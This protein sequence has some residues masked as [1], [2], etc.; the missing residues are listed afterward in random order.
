M[1]TNEATPNTPSNA[2]AQMMADWGIMNAVLGGTKTM[3][4]AGRNLLPQHQAEAQS[5]YNARLEKA[6][7]KN[8]TEETIGALSGKPFSEPIKLGDDIPADVEELLTNVDAE[9]NTLDSFAK[10]WF[11]EGIAKGFSHV[12]VEFPRL[13]PKQDGT[14]RTL[15][16]DRAE[17]V[18]PYLV[19][20]VPEN[21]I[22]ARTDI[23]GGDEV[24][25]HARIRRTVT[26]PYGEWGEQQIVE[27]MVLEPNSVRLYRQKDQTKDDSEWVKVDEWTTG[28]NFVPL[29]TFYT[30]KKDTLLSKP[31]L[32]D[33]AYVNVR[34]W[35]SA[36]DQD[37]S[38]SAA[39]FP[40]M[41]VSG[42]VE[43]DN[44]EIGP[45]KFLSTEN[46]QGKFYYVEHKGTAL[47]SGADDLQAMEDWMGSYGSE[48]LRKKSGNQTATARALDSAESTSKLQAWA[49]DFEDRLETV[50][51]F[52]KAWISNG[53]DFGGGTLSLVTDFAGSEIEAG[54]LEALS[55]SRDRKD[56]SRQAWIIE[57]KRRD[58]IAEDFDAEMDAELLKEEM[59][60]L[61]DL[62]GSI[63]DLDAGAN[64]EP[65][66]EAH[67]PTEKDAGTKDNTEQGG[68]E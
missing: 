44:F 49:L 9:G 21:L 41:A 29:V 55:K 19:H 27:I 46:T 50:L 48:F 39:R 34:H 20:V 26:I 16:D 1:A 42:A 18:R 17:G 11:E 67:K 60:A 14:A 22:F 64:P 28:I 13:E 32:L 38:L 62:G 30:N 7:L 36:S 33:L 65:D 31:P 5:R 3:R 57:M 51:S 53:T 54:S 58:I 15:E 52:M 23:V 4:Q 40:Q 43:E 2:H 56:I 45:W 24:V 35:Q 6:V 25:T 61:V 8:M 66:P 12:L 37:T 68:T 10:T 47:K 63:L 59:E